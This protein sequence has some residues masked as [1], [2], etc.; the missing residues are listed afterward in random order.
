MI[1]RDP[2]TEPSVEDTE[3]EE[4]EA[5]KQ[6]LADETKRA[7]E[8]LA[9]WQRVQADFVN[10][11]RRNE[12]EREET[13]K[14]AN[15]ELART[16]LPILDDFERALEHVEPPMAEDSW[17]EGIRLIERKLRAGLESQGV[18]EIQ[19]LG[20][21][22]D[23]NLHEAAMHSKGPDGIVVQELQK[24]YILHDR[25]IRPSMVVVGNGE[26]ESEEEIGPEDD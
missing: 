16:I 21:K 25:V 1:P 10:F 3:L 23:P 5:M 4:P 9:S 14:M 20:E 2:D 7:E 19:A 8:Y 22:F 17:V 6:A 11:K 12:Q 13:I 24:G 26:I 18:R 15:A